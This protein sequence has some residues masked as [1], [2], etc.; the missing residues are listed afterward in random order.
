[1]I[2][3]GCLSCTNIELF[4]FQIFNENLFTPIE[5]F[6]LQVLAAGYTQHMGTQNWNRLHKQYLDKVILRVK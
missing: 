6:A 5:I 3:S 2:P 1:M 4:F